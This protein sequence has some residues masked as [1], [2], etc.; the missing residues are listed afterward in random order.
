MSV[1]KFVYSAYCKLHID[2]LFLNNQP[3]ILFYHGV[4]SKVKDLGIET[5]SIS[6]ADFEHQLKYLTRHFHPISMDEFYDRFV[7]RCWDGN[8]ILLTFD[9]GYRNMLHTGLPLLEKYHV[10]FGLFLTVDNISSDLLFPTTIN[11]LVHLASS[12]SKTIDNPRMLTENTSRILK[13][14]KEE[15]V[16][17]LC[18]DMMGHVST[19]ELNQLREDYASI[20]PMNWDEVFEIA[21]SPLCTIGSHCMSHICCH[22]NQDEGEVR[23]QFSES[24]RIIS[25]RIGKDCNYL[26]YPNGSFTSHVKSIARECGYKMAF[27]TRYEAVD[28]QNVDAMA[29]GRIYVPYDYSRFVYVISR[30]PR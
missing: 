23:R 20:N 1:K 14:E 4:A 24:K 29:V 25:E 11:R 28:S 21:K 26:S 8:E 10:P 22:A 5:E 15:T 18:Q 6:A 19:E 30:F 3:R 2:R 17:A 16:Q 12:Y 7:Q 9:D 27:S 13:S